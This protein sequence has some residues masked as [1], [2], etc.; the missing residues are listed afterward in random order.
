MKI[1]LFKSAIII[2]FTALLFSQLSAQQGYKL[3]YSYNQ[4]D[5][6]RYE[7]STKLANNMEVMGQEMKTS[8]DIS[9]STK[10][11]VES[12]Q[13]NG[14]MALISS[15]DSG[16]V[17]AN[18]PMG[19]NT[20]SLDM[21]ADKKMRLIVSEKGKVITRE[22]ID[23]VEAAAVTGMANREVVYFLH[24]PENNVKI[25][26]TWTSLDTNTVTAMGGKM[27]NIINST[28][29]LTGKEN[30]L[31]YDCLKIDYTGDVKNEGNIAAMGQSLFIEGTGK[32]TGAFYFE[33]DR[34]IIIQSE[35]VVDMEM[36]LATSG[37][38]QNMIIPMTQRV[39]STL[40]IVK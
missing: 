13:S 21:L 31:G 11:N 36:T 22:E 34:G 6:Y 26:E 2:L 20:M 32:V 14:N 19:N 24:F 18:S 10:F 39:E 17:T 4:G 28:C 40:T 35:S 7:N 15:I 9:L 23:T 27:L 30:K 5:T 29:T 37:E 33:P 25:G 8:T 1:N 12:V 38:Q 16:K 3:K